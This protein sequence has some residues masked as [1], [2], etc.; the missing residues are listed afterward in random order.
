MGLIV[1]V[2]LGLIVSVLLMISFI[3][4]KESHTRIL[5]KVSLT[6]TATVFFILVSLLILYHDIPHTNFIISKMFLS[7]MVIISFFVFDLTV[8]MPRFEVKKRGAFNILNGIIH[9]AGIAAVLTFTYDFTWNTLTGFK[10]LS[11][12]AGNI[13][14]NRIITSIFLLVMPAVCIIIAAVKFIIEK[15]KIYR[16]QIIFYILTAVAMLSLFS[17]IYYITLLFSWMAVV[18]PLGYIF[19]IYFAN[20]SFSSTVIYD[21]KQVG[22]AV[23]RFVTFILIF[24]VTAGFFASIILTQVRSF[25]LQIVL[26]IFTASSFLI[27][28]NFFSLKLKEKFGALGEYE[29]RLE[30]ELQ[31]IDYTEGR[32]SVLTEFLKIMKKNVKSEDL[33]ILITDD[34]GILQPVHF[35]AESAE[36]LLAGGTAFDFVFENSISVLMRS[37]VLTD[38]EFSEIRDELIAFM[39]KTASE[40]LIFIREGQNFIGTI[41]LSKKIKEE[42]YTNYDFDVLSNLYAYFFLVAYYLRN[43]AKQDI[44]LTVD[45]EIEMSDQIIESVQKTMDVIENK[46]IQ[47]D[48]ASYTAHKLGGDFIDFIKLSESR[49][50]FLIGDISGK[51]LSASMSM[52]ILKSVLHTYLSETQDFKELVEKVNLFIKEKLPKGTFFAGLFGIID[53]KNSLIYYLNCGIPLMAMYIDSYKN[54]TEIQGEGRVLG[55]VKNIKPFLRVRKITMNKDDIIVFTTD[56]LLE[57]ENLR[58]DRFNKERVKRILSLNKEKTAGEIADI[59]YKSLIDFVS[60]QIG[61]DVTILVFKHSGGI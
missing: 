31:R 27:M 8:K 24:A 47:V 35:A 57:S 45:R 25:A 43:I 58:G 11:Y 39:D 42:A 37:Q 3:K 29:D 54:V 33:S 59:L 26:L 32:Q 21:K 52:L 5:L 49:S 23:L 55:F 28:R 48:S 53:F 6:E 22:L 18:M 15:S 19:F 41:G 38:F 46:P 20:S 51:G 14:A 4:K 1:L 56:G 12:M 13:S 61:D 34:S 2:F 44:I 30:K 36:P 9:T 10:F 16:Q 40:V 60:H 17:V 7:C 50:F